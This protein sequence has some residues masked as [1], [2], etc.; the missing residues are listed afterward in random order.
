MNLWDK[1]L[2]SSG[3]PECKSIAEHICSAISGGKN[4]FFPTNELTGVVETT[5]D[6]VG[7]MQVNNPL[8]GI[9]QE[10]TEIKGLIVDAEIKGEIEVNEELKGTKA[11]Q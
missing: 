6:L 1:I 8:I 7:E 9:V 5:I 3:I 10:N 4:I 2:A 11:C